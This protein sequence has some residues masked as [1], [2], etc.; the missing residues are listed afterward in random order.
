MKNQLFNGI[1]HSKMSQNGE[2]ANAQQQA[3]NLNQTSVI[4]FFVVDETICIVSIA[5]PD[6][7]THVFG[8]GIGKI[9]P[10][11]RI[12]KKGDV[13]T[14]SENRKQYTLHLE[15]GKWNVCLDEIF[16]LPA[17]TK[18][19]EN[20]SFRQLKYVPTAEDETTE[21]FRQ[22]LAQLVSANPDRFCLE[23]PAKKMEVRVGGTKVRIPK[24]I[25]DLVKQL[26]IRF[27]VYT[28]SFVEH[29]LNGSKNGVCRGD[30]D[31]YVL[32]DLYVLDAKQ[33]ERIIDILTK[34]EFVKDSTDKSNEYTFRLYCDV[35]CEKFSHEAIIPHFNLPEGSDPAQYYIEVEIKIATEFHKAYESNCLGYFLGLLLSRYFKISISGVWLKHGCGEIPLNV[36]SFDDFLKKLGINLDGIRTTSEFIERLLASPLIS[37]LLT[38]DD[39]LRLY[40]NIMGDEK[41]KHTSKPLR[42][43]LHLLVCGLKERFPER[44]SSLRSELVQERVLDEKSGQTIPVWRVRLF[45][46]NQGSEFEIQMEKGVLFIMCSGKKLF[47]STGADKNLLIFSEKE[48]KSDSGEKPIPESMKVCSRLFELLKEYFDYLKD[49]N[50]EN[51]IIEK[52][53]GALGCHSEVGI[54]LGKVGFELMKKIREELMKPLYPVIRMKPASMSGI[55]YGGLMKELTVVIDFSQFEAFCVERHGL[56]GDYKSFVI[57]ILNH[58]IFREY[59]SSITKATLLLEL[60]HEDD[61][62]MRGEIYDDSIR[63]IKKLCLELVSLWS[64]FHN[65]NVNWEEKGNQDFHISS[66]TYHEIT[67]DWRP[68]Y[69]GTSV[70]GEEVPSDSSAVRGKKQKKKKQLKPDL[71]EKP[72]EN[73][74]LEE[75]PQ[76]N[77]DLEE[78]LQ[79]KPVHVF[80]DGQ[81]GVVFTMPIA[82]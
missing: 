72:Q 77:P 58:K 53:I 39:I 5:S 3:Q 61:K 48:I 38:V 68:Y 19:I 30:M 8:N 79:G 57:E 43:W 46:S 18:R 20:V 11:N 56:I 10:D 42:E 51:L 40:K 23:D 28:C 59:S 67:S 62:Q 33:A 45:V 60:S 31:L 66:N 70:L 73:P 49:I 15:N 71:E 9:V 41:M 65:S 76:A 26:L 80:M 81:T 29:L 78:K 7:K 14:P 63:K 32:E 69:L 25:F 22:I 1:T 24:Q 21:S 17:G 50:S 35:L 6:G 16:G 55:V 4:T 52:F 27:R 36:D 12:T 74:V 54:H 2:E 37:E 82:E 64:I 75:K 47:V 34:L 13:Q 44:F